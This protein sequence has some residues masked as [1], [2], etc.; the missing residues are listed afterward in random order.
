MN[1]K[2]FPDFFDLPPSP[3]FILYVL[4]SNKK[5]YSKQIQEET[6]LSASTVT[7]SIRMLKKLGFI[8]L[9]SSPKIEVKKGKY[10]KIDK[11]LRY[12]KIK[13]LNHH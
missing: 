10:R 6:G 1:Y 13:E 2:E 12:W 5:M 7:V 9:T 11:R 4:N 3:K 8:E